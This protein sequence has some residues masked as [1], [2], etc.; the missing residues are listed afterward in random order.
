MHKNRCPVLKR[1][2]VSSRERLQALGETTVS[3]RK[4]KKKGNKKGIRMGNNDGGLEDNVPDSPGGL[5]PDSGQL[6]EFV[7][8]SSRDAEE[9]SMQIDNSNNMVRLI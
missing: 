3:K 6:P 9:S 7:L 4:K 2:M 5:Y 8:G 1:A